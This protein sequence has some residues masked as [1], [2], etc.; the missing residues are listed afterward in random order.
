[1]DKEVAM[2][3]GYGYGYG[4]FRPYVSVAQRRATAA[5]ETAKLARKGRVISPVNID[6][7]TIAHSFWG[8]GWCEHLESY[9][10]F[11]N[12]L[13]RG[14]TYVRNGSVVDLQI[15]PGKISAMVMGSE[16]YNIE[17]GIVPL[18]KDRWQA[19]KRQCA[20][21]IKSVLELLK[22]GISAGVMEVMS[23]RET[24]MFPAPKE[25]DMDCS[26][27]DWAGLCKH[28]AAVLYGVGAR[29]DRQPELLFTLRQVDPSELIAQATSALTQVTDRDK[30]LRPDELAD[31]F[32]IDLVQDASPAGAPATAGVAAAS[33]TSA[34][35]VAAASTA[36][37]SLPVRVI[38]PV[39]RRAAALRAKPKR[40]APGKSK[41]DT[42][43]KTKFAVTRARRRAVI[44]ATAV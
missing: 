38:R 24:G 19:L 34:T 23:H 31:V 16:M 42:G 35:S 5:R 7:R 22:G 4:G 26:C 10:D 13:P 43:V 2:G 32:G 11:S 44:P 25:I 33:A 8:K 30:N 14:R 18:K 1:L 27:P 3:W 36:P 40:K 39:I 17:I 28:L 15:K 21:K 12:R 41:P 37:Q 6:G 20:G 9:S 29:L